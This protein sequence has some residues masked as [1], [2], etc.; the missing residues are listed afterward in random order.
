MPPA[1][2]SVSLPAPPV[3]TFASAL[4]I[5]AC[6][7]LPVPV[8]FSTLAESVKV[9]AAVRTSSIPSPAS[10]TIVSFASAW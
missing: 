8:R 3:M 1:P 9:E 6:P 2:L 10:S 7:A 4:P 5:S